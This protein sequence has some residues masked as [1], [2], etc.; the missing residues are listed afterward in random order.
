MDPGLAVAIG[1][2]VGSLVAMTG[3]LLG[4]ELGWR[5]ATKQ[6]LLFGERE[7]G[8]TGPVREAKPD[9]VLLSEEEE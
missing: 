5:A 9:E 1:A 2:G 8:V 4:L 3:I 7:R 6:P